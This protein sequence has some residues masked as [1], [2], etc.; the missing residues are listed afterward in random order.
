[1]HDDVAGKDREERC[2]G[3][4]SSV[5]AATN[6]DG[7]ADCP[8]DGESGKTEIRAAGYPGIRDRWHRNEHGSDAAQ[9]GKADD[10][11]I[12][13][14]SIAPRDIYPGRHDRRDQREIGD[15]ERNRP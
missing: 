9:C 1:P 13:E 10:A 2:P 3:S 14:T 15:G 5:C 7:S 4:P 12:E 6:E 8:E 11:G